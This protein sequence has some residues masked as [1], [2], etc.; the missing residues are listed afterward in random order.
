VSTVFEVSIVI[1]TGSIQQR[2][3]EV[4]LIVAALCLVA[5]LPNQTARAAGNDW[6]GSQDDLLVTVDARW[7]GCTVGGYY[8]IRIRLQ[9]R[10]AAR[11]VTVTFAPNDSGLPAVTRT[12]DLAQNASASTSLLVPMVGSTNYGEF[13]VSDDSGPLRDLTNHFSLADAD[14]S[15]TRL[16]LLAISDTTVDCAGFEGAVSSLLGASHG[17]WGAVSTEDHQ[18]IPPVMLPD[19][20][21]AYSGLDL[22]SISKETL[23]GLSHETRT[24]LFNWVKANG[25]LLVY[26]VGEDPSDAAELDKL[27]GFNQ[28]SR[29]TVWTAARPER[30]RA[31]T[32]REFDTNGN[33]STHTP[34]ADEAE[35][36][37]EGAGDAFAI[38]SLGMGQIVGIKGDPFPGSVH[39]WGWLLNT[40]G[41]AR[42]KH[43][44]RL[45]ASGRTENE[46]FLH[47]LIPG[48]QSVP[49][50]SFLIFISVF[51]FVIGPLNYYMLARRK[52]LNL[53]VVTIPAVATVTSLL[54][55][56]YSAV[57]HG[58]SVKS[59]VRSLTILDQNSQTAV[60]MA[61]I[62]L[63]AG[64]T[65]S[66][67]LEFSP[68]T[69]V[70]PIWPTG[71]EFETGRVDWTE[72]QALRSGFLRSRTRTQFLT[73]E[74][75]DERG[76]LTIDNSDVGLNVANGLEWDLAALIVTDDDGNMFFGK[77][78]PAG[79][80][81]KL[82]QMSEAD[83]E[84]ATK[85]LRRS[86]PAPPDELA[87]AND[88]TVF[89]GLTSRHRYYGYYNHTTFSVSTG[90]MELQINS[91]R[92]AM[93]GN[94]QLEKRSYV[95]FLKEGSEKS[96]V[97][98]GTEVTVVDDWH[99]IIGYY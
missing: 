99:V 19:A 33:E 67:G 15:N 1:R 43:G 28:A 79:G 53:L 87:S 89:G 2:R 22:V 90:Q 64:F 13:R 55:F 72:T 60:S 39:D 61:R 51:T 91:L 32:I 18:V 86:H 57:A 56:A 71:Q 92:Q 7:A 76:R 14:P 24:A 21:I 46:E 12:V 25:T 17:R 6:K 4:A 96:P 81:K 9:N 84:A 95:A 98:F 80:S 88:V 83:R 11:S 68:N 58:F 45:G 63:Y 5:A 8:P 16:S 54:L 73:T 69:S 47:F 27:V 65:P 49:V 29:K 37:W 77:S 26:K 36:E 94:T 31:I 30:R 48:I 44:D 23:E 74:V 52:K 70:T 3:V 59:R 97:E 35:F 20:W 50:F 93:Q 62:G 82:A 66:G 75:R 85:L 34:A 40:L 10:A 42:L 78:V 38:R 41:A